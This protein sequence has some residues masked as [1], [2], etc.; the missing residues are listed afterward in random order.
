ML[1][2]S[3]KSLT[4]GR[5][6][7]KNTAL[8][9]LGQFLPLAVG[10][11]AIPKLIGGLG[12]ER[13]GI[14]TLAWAIIGYSSL[15]DLGLGRALTKLVAERID[16]KQQDELPALIWTGLLLMVIAGAIGAIAMFFASSWLVHS[17]LRVSSQL[18]AETVKTFQ[19]LALSVPLVIL[20]T[21]FR[22]ILEAHQLFTLVTAVRLPLGVLTFAVPWFL[23]LFSHSLVVIVV[24]LVGVRGLAC[25][26][27]FL[28][29]AW[30]YPTLVTAVAFRTSMAKVLLGFG[31]WMT[32]TNVVG[33]VM[34]N[35]D[36]FLIGA[37]VSTAAVAYYT[38]PYEMITK[39]WLFP[40]A[41]A[42]VLFPAFSS[43]MKEPTRLSYLFD[44][45]LTYV[46]LLLFLPTLFITAFAH[47]GIQLWL[48][49]SFAANSTAI[50]QLLSIG[51]LINSVSQI[52]FAFIQGIGRPDL[53]AKLHFAELPVYLSLAYA[54]IHMY[55]A[56]GAAIAWLVRVTVDAVI[57]FFISARLLPAT[58][59]AIQRASYRIAAIVAVSLIA[60]LLTTWGRMLF[61]LAMTGVFVKVGWSSVLGEQERRLFTSRFRTSLA[62][63]NSHV[64]ASS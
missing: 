45:G 28:C 57:L 58:K 59:F 19:Y 6:L 27:Q 36:R 63:D 20:A 46:M 2:D 41:L 1:V 42:G 7:F 9:F 40:F 62:V 49:K 4:S 34:T 52:P 23:L 15:F 37:I 60:A 11:F 12:I 51:V 31:G 29:V 17:V 32:V 61:V 48:G 21:G 56:R 10:L 39:L 50:L 8:N 24:S 38:T 16:C 54:L 22:G 26:A 47:F 18:Q 43:L 64:N 5:L 35:L 13:F 33:P 44:R 30:K 3:P 55:G 14:L 25:I 53:T